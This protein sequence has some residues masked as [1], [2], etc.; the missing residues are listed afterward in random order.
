VADKMHMD[1]DELKQA[2]AILN[3]IP[4]D[5]H[6]PD[7]G[8]V[9]VDELSSVQHLPDDLKGFG[10]NGGTASSWIATCVTDLYTYI[11]KLVGDM[12]T[13]CGG[14]GTLMDNSIKAY[15]GED[16]NSKNTITQSGPDSKG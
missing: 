1:V 3:L 11:N 4:H 7:K 15:T 16:T 5:L 8:G 2:L 12:Q 13:T 6:A 10:A 9:P 14:I